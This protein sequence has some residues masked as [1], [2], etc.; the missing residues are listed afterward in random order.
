MERVTGIEPA[1]P[2]WKPGHPQ[3]V[4]T[5][6][7]RAPRGVVVIVG[8][9]SFGVLRNF[10]AN[11]AVGEREQTY[12]APPAVL[13]PKQGWDASTTRPRRLVSRLVP[14][15][16]T[17]QEAERRLAPDIEVHLHLANSTA[18]HTSTVHYDDLPRPRSKT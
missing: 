4:G 17:S 12:L 13:S 7:L 11:S 15:G 1:W 5:D 8:E 18:P 6:Q 3:L 9:V 10:C 16:E 2:A 14:V